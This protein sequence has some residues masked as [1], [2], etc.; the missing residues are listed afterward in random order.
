MPAQDLSVTQRR[1]S[2]R[3][4]DV[5]NRVEVAITG[6]AVAARDSK[7][8]SGAMLVVSPRTWASATALVRGGKFG[9][10]SGDS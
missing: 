5:A 1:K 3:S 4:S 7:H 10:V 6:A 9:W 8:L 2:S